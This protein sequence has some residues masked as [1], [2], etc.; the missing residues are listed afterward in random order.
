MSWSR[1]LIWK[2]KK[3][4]IGACLQVQRVSPWL[5]CLLEAATGSFKSWFSGT[6]AEREILSLLKPQSPLP[7]THSLIPPKELT[8]R[9][10]ALYSHFLH[11][12]FRTYTAIA[13]LLAVVNFSKSRKRGKKM[14]IKIKIMNYIQKRMIQDSTGLPLGWMANVVLWTRCSIWQMFQ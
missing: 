13:P 11:I 9:G 14:S 7:L 5:S 12:S 3:H 2:K 8:R 1:Q 6:K 10:W 4:L